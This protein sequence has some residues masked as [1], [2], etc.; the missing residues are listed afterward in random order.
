MKKLFFLLFILLS[1][2]FEVVFLDIFRIFNVKPNLLLIIV[3]VASLCFELRWALFFSILAGASKDIFCANLIGV[4]TLMFTLLSFLIYK[5]SREITLDSNLVSI[6]L[7]FF[8]V[9]VNDIIIRL[10]FVYL[11]KY[12]PLGIFLRTTFLEALYTMLIAPL[13]FKII[14]P[15]FNS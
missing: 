12:I 5:L 6:V 9:L 13:V 1:V 4:N 8:I 7:I 10:V 11:G 2:F 14:K 3:V 15:E